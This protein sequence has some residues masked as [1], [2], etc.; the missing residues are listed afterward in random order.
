MKSSLCTDFFTSIISRS[1]NLGPCQE[2][3]ANC[4]V[5]LKTH[6]V[7]GKFQK[8]CKN[9]LLIMQYLSRQAM[10]NKSEKGSN[11]NQITQP[12]P[13]KIQVTLP[14]KENLH[15]KFQV[16]RWGAENCRLYCTS[17]FLETLAIIV[18]S[19][20]GMKA[21]DGGLDLC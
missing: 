18:L 4:Q 19:F 13:S 17:W 20:R 14:T 7:K 21:L 11:L 1:E 16:Q 10:L 8:T 15:I 3:I 5:P 9:K 2:W 12:Y 6:N